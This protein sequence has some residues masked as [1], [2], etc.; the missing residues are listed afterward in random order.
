M[1]RLFQNFAKLFLFYKQPRMTFLFS[2][3][4]K[5]SEIVCRKEML[6]RNYFIISRHH[7][8][9]IPQQ[10]PDIGVD[11][12]RKRELV[13]STLFNWCYTTKLHSILIM[14]SEK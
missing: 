9:T 10:L 2:F 5:A 14:L 4:K 6:W 7:L 3:W 12:G 13:R 11:I 8:W 1:L